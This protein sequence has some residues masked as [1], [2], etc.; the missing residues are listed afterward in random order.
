LWRDA[1]TRFDADIDMRDVAGGGIF[2]PGDELADLR[3]IRKDDPRQRVAERADDLVD[4]GRLDVIDDPSR[5]RLRA[6][7]YEDNRQTDAVG[8]QVA[9]AGG[10]AHQRRRRSFAHEDLPPFQVA[11]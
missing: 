1:A 4:V 3:V 10:K 9:I 5:Q 8:H 7:Q 2:L 11:I 6:G